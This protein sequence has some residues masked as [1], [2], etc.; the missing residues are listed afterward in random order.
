M[1]I[2][3]VAILISLF[4]LLV[5]IMSFLST[6]QAA[7]SFRYYERWFQLAR[8]V[9]DRADVLLPLWCNSVQYQRLYAAEI[10]L[11]S[12]FH[13]EELLFAEMYIDFLLEVHRR[14]AIAAFF[15]GRFPGQ[16]PLTNP[17]MVRIWNEHVRLFYSDRYQK[18]V[19]R[20]IARSA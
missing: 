2:Q 4:A 12:D 7:W 1:P 6:R 13:P 19:D 8:I 20:V 9:L 11:D 14:G 10:P 18:V 17:R 3:T 16:V 5:S 15:T